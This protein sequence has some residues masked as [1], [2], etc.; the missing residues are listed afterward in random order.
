MFPYIAVYSR[1]F[2]GYWKSTAKPNNG[3]GNIADENDVT[4]LAM[5]TTMLTTEPPIETTG[6][7]S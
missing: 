7:Q 2:P 6:R 4:T 1:I 5:T 3:R